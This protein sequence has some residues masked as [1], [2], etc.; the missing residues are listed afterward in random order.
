MADTELEIVNAEMRDIYKLL[1][2]DMQKVTS[3]LTKLETRRAME[4][5][6]GSDEIYSSVKTLSILLAN[7]ETEQRSAGNTLGNMR[8]LI[9][10]MTKCAK[11][12]TGTQVDES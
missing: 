2:G 11:V 8:E 3:Y 9:K 4:D 5:Q 12:T 6:Q 7:M 10:S 1:Q